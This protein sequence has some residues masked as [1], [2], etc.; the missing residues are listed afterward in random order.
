[1]GEGFCQRLAACPRVREH[2][3]RE[4]GKNQRSAPNAVNSYVRIQ[5]IF[6]VVVM[7]TGTLFAAEGAFKANKDWKVEVIRQVPEVHSPSVVT[8][9]PDG[10][11]FVAAGAMGMGV[12]AKDPADRI[13]CI[14]PDGHQTVFAEKLHAVYGMQYV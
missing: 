13:L 2:G 14:F 1:E 12:P 3:T 7:G 6:C 11:I 5:F 8:C 4:K 9:A 10:R